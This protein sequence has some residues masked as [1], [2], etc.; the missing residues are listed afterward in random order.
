MTLDFDAVIAPMT[1]AE[2]L[3]DYWDKSFVRIAGEAGRFSHLLDWDELNA[4]LEQHRLAPPRLKLYLGGRAV[5]AQRFLTPAMFGVPRLDAGGLAAC[6]A[7]GA[8]LILDDAQEVAPLRQSLCQLA[9]PECV[10]PALG[11]PILDHP[12]TDGPQAL[13]RIPA[14]AP[15]PAGE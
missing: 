13:G 4:I 2:F 1:R 14:H 15:Q 7:Q 9:R 10:R 12:A 8:S 11:P 6:L 3:R 5:E